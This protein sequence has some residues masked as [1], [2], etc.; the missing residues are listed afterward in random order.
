VRVEQCRWL[1]MSFHP[2][3]NKFHPRCRHYTPLV[4]CPTKEQR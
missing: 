4:R 3:S 2:E 1:D